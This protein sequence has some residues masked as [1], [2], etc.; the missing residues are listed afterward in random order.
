MRMEDLLNQAVA[1]QD[2]VTLVLGILLLGVPLVLKGFGLKVPMVDQIVE[3]GKKLLALKA[4]AA[5][6]PPPA[7]GERTGIAAIVDIQDLK[8]GV[9]AP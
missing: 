6:V 2:Y 9:M 3:A 4:K 5:V 1:N 8:K 7:E